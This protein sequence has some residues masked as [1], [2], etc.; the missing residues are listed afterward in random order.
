MQNGN[1]TKRTVPLS[2]GKVVGSTQDVVP[3][4]LGIN[5]CDKFELRLRGKGP[6]AVLSIL[7]E[8]TVGSEK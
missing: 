1:E 3:M 5:R 2:C 8:F 4:R 6:C 7:R